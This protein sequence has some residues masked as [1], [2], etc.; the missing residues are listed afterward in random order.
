MDRVSSVVFCGR[1][2]LSD[3]PLD[4]HFANANSRAGRTIAAPVSSGKA[5]ICR[6]DPRFLHDIDPNRRVIGALY[7][8]TLP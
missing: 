5:S 7:A 6:A 8:W 1:A 4:A 2:G 3:R